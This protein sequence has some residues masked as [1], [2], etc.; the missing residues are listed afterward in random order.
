[1]IITEPGE[2]LVIHSP[3]SKFAGWAVVFW[4][5]GNDWEV[6]SSWWGG[7]GGG[8]VNKGSVGKASDFWGFNTSFKN[9][10]GFSDLKG[11]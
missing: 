9:F 6:D 5:V 8:D 3:S 11:M 7:G 4:Q 10:K 1:M 2:Q